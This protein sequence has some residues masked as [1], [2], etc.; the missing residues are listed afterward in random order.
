MKRLT[1]EDLSGA[2]CHRVQLLRPGE[3]VRVLW[4]DR[5]T[6]LLRRMDMPTGD[7][8]AAMDTEGVLSNLA[9]WIEFHDVQMGLGIQDATFDMEVPEDAVRV[10]ELITPPVPPPQWLG[11]APQDFAFLQTDGGTVT[12]DSLAGKVVVLDFW[13]TGCGPCQQSMPALERLFQTYRHNSGFQFFAV[14][15]DP[16]EVSDDKL[17]N[18]LEEWGGSMPVLR[19]INRRAEEQFDVTG[20]PSTIVLGPS[21]TMQLVARGAKNSYEDWRGTIDRLLADEDVA[22]QLLAEHRKAHVEYEAAVAAATIDNGEPA[23]PPDKSSTKT[24]GPL[25]D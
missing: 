20:Y 21:G 24:D 1:D 12:P 13:F 2:A 18:T 19:D 4:I 16:P 14:S 25:E 17:Q 22:R 7:V 11:K 8:R 3:G 9:L 6:Y 15:V 10:R 23:D 5:K